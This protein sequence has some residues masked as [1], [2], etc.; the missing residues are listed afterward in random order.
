M[1]FFILFLYYFIFSI[2]SIRINKKVSLQILITKC[3]VNANKN[4]E[5]IY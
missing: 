3:V 1:D 2:I 5:N 4:E